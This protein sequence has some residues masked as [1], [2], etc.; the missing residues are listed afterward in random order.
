MWGLQVGWLFMHPVRLSIRF[1]I[2]WQRWN[3]EPAH[4]DFAVETES[5]SFL[6]LAGIL[7]MYPAFILPEQR[8]ITDAKGTHITPAE[9][10]VERIVGGKTW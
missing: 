2:F 9:G 7:V 6:C 10:L 4:R 3:N 1:A 8:L 5:Q